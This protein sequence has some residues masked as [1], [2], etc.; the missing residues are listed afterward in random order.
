[1]DSVRDLDFSS[2]KSIYFL[3]LLEITRILN[4][5]KDPFFHILLLI[6]WFS[7]TFDSQII[8]P[9]INFLDDLKLLS[10]RVCRDVHFMCTHKSYIL[11]TFM[12][13]RKFYYSWKWI[14][15]GFLWIYKKHGSTEYTYF[16][17]SVCVVKAPI[18]QAEARGCDTDAV[19]L[20]RPGVRLDGNFE[21]WRCSIFRVQSLH[22]TPEVPRRY[23]PI[24]HDVPSPW[25]KRNK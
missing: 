13:H 3:V 10:I 5:N 4:N 20:R 25:K 8:T 24:S 1:M 18:W 19:V 7:H 17:V 6:L 9:V 23:A 14:P 21:E 22:D 2:F 12:F 16:I 11:H 15:R